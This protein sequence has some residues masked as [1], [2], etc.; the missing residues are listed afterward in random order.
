MRGTTRANSVTGACAPDETSPRGRT[1]PTAWPCSSAAASPRSTA[2]KSYYEAPCT[3]FVAEF[4]GKT[5][6]IEGRAE[7]AETFTRG[8]MRLRVEGAALTPGA[9]A[10]LSIRPHQIEL[11]PATTFGPPPSDGAPRR[12]APARATSGDAVDYQVEVA[13]SDVVLRV[14]GPT[15][16]RLQPGDAVWLRVVRGRALPS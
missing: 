8:R 11:R 9:P 4:I 12:R 5:N 16:P 10:V 1:S 14:A 15:A 13:D 3:R 2:Q 6:L 7:D